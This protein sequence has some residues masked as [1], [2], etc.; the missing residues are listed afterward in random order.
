ERGFNKKTFLAWQIG[1]A[2]STG[3]ALTNFLTN[4]GFTTDETKRAGLSVLRSDKAV[5][6]FRARIMIPLAD[7]QGR[8]IGFTARLLADEPGA[9]KYI[10]TPATVIYDKSRHVFGLHLAKESIRKSGFAV[11]VEGQMD[12]ISSHQVGVTN[13]VATAG[14]AMTENHL[15]EI[16]RFSGDIRLCFDN[17]QAGLAATERAIELAQKAGVSL[18]IVELKDAKDAD[19]LIKKDPTQW[20]T[21]IQKSV[22]AIDWLV[23]HY[24]KNLDLKSAQGKKAYSDA[25][26][27][28]IRRLA[29]PVEQEHY[30]KVVAEVADTTLGAIKSKANR[31]P[32]VTP[33]RY[34][35][36]KPSD[37]ARSI[38]EVEYQRFKNHFLALVLFNLK[39]R[40][41]LKDMRP[42][43]FDDPQSLEL[44]NL[45]KENPQLKPATAV[46]NLQDYGKILVLQYEELYQELDAE[47]MKD[48]ALQLKH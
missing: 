8:I 2:P 20:E 29:D 13:V 17:D 27:P 36:V 40:N 46:Q 44:Y 39:L 23:D 15:R 10:N 31:E 43:F 19:E 33:T 24:K 3:H 16:K 22:Y 5:D 42:E 41:L 9:P 45:L 21:A 47:N 35:Q 18:S 12:V 34:R 37:E 6:M 7:S 4:H 32:G 14:T 1:Y 30:L 38:E 25:L 26:L 48:Q 28:T 11:V